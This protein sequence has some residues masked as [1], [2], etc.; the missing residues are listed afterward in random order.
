MKTLK[1]LIILAFIASIGLFVFTNYKINSY[2]Y[3]KKD[4]DMKFYHL[5][6][7]TKEVIY[8]LLDE[9]KAMWGKTNNTKKKFDTWKYVEYNL[10]EFGLKLKEREE[11]LFNIKASLFLDD[12]NDLYNLQK[13]VG[14]DLNEFNLKIEEYKKDAEKHISD[15]KE[16][17][18]G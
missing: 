13:L 18:E 1:I 9:E 10:N 6:N 7:G 12:L 17:V 11:D 3:N 8:N 16:L 5:L 14:K 4:E 2:I 15:L